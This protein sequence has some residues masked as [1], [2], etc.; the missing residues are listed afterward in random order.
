MKPKV[1]DPKEITRSEAFF[2]NPFLIWGRY[3]SFWRRTMLKIS[4]QFHHTQMDG[5]HAGKF[6]ELLQNHIDSIEIGG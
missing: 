2:N 4:F 5:A 6:L 3:Q 1:I